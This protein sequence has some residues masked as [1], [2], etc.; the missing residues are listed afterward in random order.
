MFGRLLNLQKGRLFSW[1]CCIFSRGKNLGHSDLEDL[2]RIKVQVWRTS[3]TQTL[4]TTKTVLRIILLSGYTYNYINSCR[5]KSFLHVP[6]LPVVQS[7]NYNYKNNFLNYY[8]VARLQLQLQELFPCKLL[9]NNF[10]DH[11]VLFF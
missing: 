1:V 8:F 7:I 3:S 2:E 4:H 5:E 11:N 10:V 6:L 9:R